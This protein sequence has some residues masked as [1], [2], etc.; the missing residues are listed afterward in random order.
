MFP[1]G[2]LYFSLCK[3]TIYESTV[4]AAL[5]AVVFVKKP[6][7]AAKAA[8]TK[9]HIKSCVPRHNRYISYRKPNDSARIWVIAPTHS[10]V[11]M[12]RAFLQHPEVDIGLPLVG[13]FDFVNEALCAI[14]RLVRWLIRSANPAALRAIC[15]APSIVLWSP[16]SRG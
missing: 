5:A 14:R 6:K 4:G 8:P 11:S 12:Y 2:L 7:T 3:Q 10:L 16:S 9:G 15:L 13:G 1:R